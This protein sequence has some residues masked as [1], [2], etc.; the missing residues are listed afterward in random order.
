MMNERLNFKISD[1]ILNYCK[2]LLSATGKEQEAAALVMAR[3][4]TR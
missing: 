2:P 3:L 4:V 1:R